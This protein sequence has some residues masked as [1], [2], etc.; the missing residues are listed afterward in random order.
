MDKNKIMPATNNRFNLCPGD[1]VLGS[2]YLLTT[3]VLG[4]QLVL[5]IRAQLK[6]AKRWTKSAALLLSIGL[7]LRWMM[8]LDR[9]ADFAHHPFGGNGR[10]PDKHTTLLKLTFQNGHPI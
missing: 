1:V 2:F 6:P 5:S 4:G 10:E 9:Y 7:P 8:R 3:L